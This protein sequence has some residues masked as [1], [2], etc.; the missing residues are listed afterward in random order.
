M[1][2]INLSL[3]ETFKYRREV[4]IELPDTITEKEL[5]RLISKAERESE[6]ASDVPHMI[7]RINPEVVIVEYVDDDMD[8]P[9]DMEVE[10]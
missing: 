3:E 8:C 7:K 6:L 2:K 1:K 5:E 9:N 4:V 10:I